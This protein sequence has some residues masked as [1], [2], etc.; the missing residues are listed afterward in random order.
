M[1]SSYKTWDI[2]SYFY[3]NIRNKA[4]D[5]KQ[6]PRGLKI[7]LNKPIRKVFRHSIIIKSLNMVYYSNFDFIINSLILS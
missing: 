1:Y 5:F 6:N 4:R 7:H 2:A 3:G